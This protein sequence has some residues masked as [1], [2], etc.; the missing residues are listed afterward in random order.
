MS[1]VYEP[2]Y[3]Y[4]ENFD[5]PATDEEVADFG[6]GSDADRRRGGLPLVRVVVGPTANG[7][8]L[9]RAGLQSRLRPMRTFGGAPPLVVH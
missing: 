2:A 6:G 4:I 3:T 7:A 1:V 9:L 8:R 5:P